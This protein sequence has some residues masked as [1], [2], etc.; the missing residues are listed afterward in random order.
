MEII[1]CKNNND[2]LSIRTPAMALSLSGNGKSILL[3]LA[4][5]AVALPG[6]GYASELPAREAAVEEMVVTGSRLKRRDFVSPSPIATLEQTDIAAA[7][8]A[9]LEEMLNQMPQ[10]VPDLGR[11]SNNPGNGMARVNLRG[12]GAER[13]LVLV[14][15]RRQAPSSVD[16]SVDINNIP[17]ALVERVEIIT[18]GASAVYGS[19]AL[20]GVVN[21]IM[22]EDFRGFSVDTDHGITERG[23]AGYRDVN[24]AFG[25]DFAH[26]RGNLVVHG[27]FFERDELFA[28]A[29]ELTADVWLEDTTSGHLFTGGSAA[30][31][32]TLISYPDGTSI[33]FTTFTEDGTPRAFDGPDDLYNYQEVNYLQTPLTRHSIGVMGSYEL[34]SGYELSFESSLIENLAAQELAPVPVFAH[35]T[36][37]TSNPLLTPE[38]EEFLSENFLVGP[39]LASFFVSRRLTELGPRR[40][41]TERDYWRSVIGVQ[42][43]LG[44][45][46]EIDGWISYTR[47]NELQLLHNDGSASRFNQALIV[48]P[49][50][51]EC[52]DLT[53][54]CVPIDIFGADR[55]SEEAAEFLRVPA[56]RNVSKREQWVASAFV[57]GAPLQTWAGP[58]DTATGFEWRGDSSTF[59][60]DE[61]LFTNDTLGYRGDAPVDGKERVAEVYTEAAVPLMKDARFANYLGLELGARYS[62]FDTSGGAWTYKFG[63]IWEPNERLRLRAMYQSSVRAPNS[64]ELFQRQFSE[65]ATLV[66]GDPSIDPCS[67]S[68]NPVDNGHLQRCVIQGLPVDQV[69]VF[70]A[71]P[72]FQARTIYGGNTELLPEEAKTFTIGA[73]FTPSVL[74]NMTLAVDYYDIEIANAIGETDPSAIC[75]DALNTQNLFCDQIVR[76]PTGDIVELRQI[77]NNL[78]LVTTRGIDTQLRYITALPDRLSLSDEGA[79]LSLYAVWT[80]LL[81]VSNREAPFSATIECAGFFGSPCAGLNGTAVIDRVS[82]NLNYTSGPYSVILGSRWIEGTRNFRSVAWMYTG[83]EEPVLAIPRIGSEHFVN[84]HATYEFSDGLSASLGIANLFDNEAPLM[85]DATFSNNTDTLLYDVFGRSY[86]LSFRLQL[87]N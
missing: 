37:N 29:R 71:T 26:G 76:G 87:G 83:Q 4:C 34:Q 82:T 5:L 12:M 7:P 25:R 81:D 13:T 20:V 22:K 55:I 8:Q 79:Q 38:T 85:A 75:F 31:P 63:G 17:K 57:S 86:N 14:N 54:G 53:G 65:P 18:G 64:L 2:L 10:I 30:I 66:R 6:G 50:T 33:G 3:A 40:L 73:I 36:I 60:A 15:S 28:S 68:Q 69:G 70:E 9:T 80:H 23:D 48:D 78:G 21:F 41:E 84:L 77:N 49:E 1:I 39:D 51:R 46:W 62:E 56:L 61:A 11:T 19:D 27:G 32:S 44:R 47:S 43:E 24:V 52:R 58:V 74:P 42:G 16:S 35:P 67:A 59:T 45:G 72:F